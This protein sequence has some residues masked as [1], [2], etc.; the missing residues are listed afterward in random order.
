MSE[1]AEIHGKGLAGMG[2]IAAMIVVIVFFCAVG[3]VSVLY[4]PA[5][6]RAPFS[7]QRAGVLGPALVLLIYYDLRE[8]RLP[9]LLTLPLILSGLAF[10]FAEEGRDALILSL[11]GA[12]IGYALI[13]LVHFIYLRLRGREGIGLGDAKLLAAG[14]AWLGPLAIGPILLLASMLSL[15]IYLAV[16]WSRISLSPKNI[17]LPFGPG[18]ACAIW[19][20][21]WTEFV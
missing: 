18:L 10:A 5:D 21:A 9:D 12:V 20:L 15:V 14:G 2:L 13:W 3:L 17:I 8:F 19:S 16:N 6:I 1:E 4:L 7:L 11:A